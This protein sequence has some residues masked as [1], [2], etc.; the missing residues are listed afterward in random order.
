MFA[1]ALLLL[2]VFESLPFASAASDDE[3]ARWWQDVEALAG[4]AM[5]GRLAGTAEYRRAAEYVAAAFKGAGLAPAGTDG[6]FQPVRFVSRQL[7]PGG[8]TLA[9]VREGRS[10]PLTVGDEAVIGLRYTPS[11][12][13]DAGLVFAGYGLSIPEAGHD[14][15]SELD[16]RGRIVVYVAGAPDGVSADLLAHAQSS[17]GRWARLAKAGAVGLIALGGAATRDVPWDR[18]VHL[19]ANPTMRLADESLD[20][21]RGQQIGLSV[22]ESGAAKLLE[23]TG[24]DAAALLA[25]A[26][27]HAALPHFAIPSRLQAHLAFTST[28]VTADNVV[29]VRRGSD[30]AV[31]AEHVVL[32]AHLDHVGVGEPIDGDRI[33]NGAMDNASGIA[34][35]LGAA[36]Q[37]G[38]APPRRSLVF[39]AVTA[40]EQGLL[41]SRYFAAHPTVA[42]DAIVADVNVDMFLPLYPMRSV[43]GY[44]AD[45][46][47]LGDDLRRAAADAGVSVVADPEPAR[48]SF[49]RSDQYSFIRAGIPA[50]ALKLGYSLGSPEHEIVKTWRE[51]RYHAPSDDLA[52]P[53]DRGA[54][55]AFNRLYVSLARSIANRP[56]RPEWK[57]TS[58]FRRFARGE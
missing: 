55:A 17:A 31:A 36:R 47:D 26:A 50:L 18:V 42:R 27:R 53:I 35:L 20:D 7:V 9:V 41:G 16:V 23:G 39:L 48:R 45:E 30:P 34:T 4:D 44:G 29:G 21:T 5:Q 1:S 8:S 24:Q 37:L 58:F 57:E 14:D 38:D 51:K 22:N 11:E 40:E 43:I 15:L 28:P 13:V 32:S 52:Q 25:L 12:T 6:Y 2:I 33:Y 49:V 56:A 10:T 19:A 54:V 3:T 46:S